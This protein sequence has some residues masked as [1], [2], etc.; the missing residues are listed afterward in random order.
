[1]TTWGNPAT[2]YSKDAKSHRDKSRCGNC[3]HSL[4]YHGEGRRTDGPCTCTDVEGR[5]CPCK[6]GVSP[7]VR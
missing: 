2:S 1:M 3:G 5:R 4:A 6:R 7:E